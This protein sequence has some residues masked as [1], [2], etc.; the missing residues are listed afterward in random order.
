M[1]FTS[2]F[3]FSVEISI[4][5][6]YFSVFVFNVLIFTSP[7]SSSV[8]IFYFSVSAFNVLIFPSPFFFS[9]EISVV[10]FFYFNFLFFRTFYFYRSISFY[11]SVFNKLYNENQNQNV[12]INK[13]KNQNQNRQS[14]PSCFA[15]RSIWRIKV[16]IRRSTALLTMLAQVNFLILPPLI[17]LNHKL[18][19]FSTYVL[20]LLFKL[21]KSR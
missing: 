4:F 3:S 1:I 2:P 15:G 20:I 13:T 14:R 10:N 9:V 12:M 18:Y 6:F 7:F 11:F 5:I 21:W 19:F 17:A 16:S 8:F